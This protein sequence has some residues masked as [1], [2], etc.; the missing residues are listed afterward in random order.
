MWEW[1]SGLSLQKKPVDL[2][3]IPDGVHLLQKPWER[4]TAM[5]GIVDWFRFWLQDQEDPDP[6][7]PQQYARWRDLRKAQLA[8]AQ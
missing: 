2:I 4:R 1:F 7:N 8:Q 3:E 5:E 6:V